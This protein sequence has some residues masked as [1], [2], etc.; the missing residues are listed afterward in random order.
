MHEVCAQYLLFNFG[1]LRT[2]SGL[3]LLQV[4]SSDLSKKT[5]ESER[6]KIK[7]ATFSLARFLKFFSRDQRMRLVAS[8]NRGML[9]HDL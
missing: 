8:P 1:Q 6:G 7:R 5:R 4:S 3:D 9:F 2:E